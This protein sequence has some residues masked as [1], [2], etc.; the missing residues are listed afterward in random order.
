MLDGLK[1]K[2]AAKAIGSLLSSLAKDKDTQTTITGLIAAAVIAL[3]LDLEKLIAGDPYQIARLV[4]G[5][6]VAVIG[7]FATKAKKDGMTTG[8][9]GLAGVLYG[10]TGQIHDIVMGVM[11]WLVG[12]FTDKPTKVVHSLPE[13]KP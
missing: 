3:Q 13:Q 10:C 4:A 5:L 8:A 6:L 2:I 7:Y 12:Y 9:G 11:I 1:R